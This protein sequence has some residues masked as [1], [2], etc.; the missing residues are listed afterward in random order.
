MST[1]AAKTKA[2]ATDV[3]FDKGMMIVSLSDG[4]RIAAPLAWFPRLRDAKD[5][6]RRKWRLIAKGV[7][8]RWD[9]L[10]EDV[11]VAALLEA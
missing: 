4:R 5:S 7:G 2:Y 9:E 3:A 1:S 11:S 10:D 6:Q 8:I